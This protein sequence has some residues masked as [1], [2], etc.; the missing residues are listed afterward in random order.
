MRAPASTALVALE[1]SES[2]VGG[3]DHVVTPGR[4]RAGALEVV[5]IIVWNF[6]LG[7]DLL[8]SRVGSHTIYGSCASPARRAFTFNFN[9]NVIFAILSPADVTYLS[10]AQATS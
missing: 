10:A 1:G 4:F 3:A 7:S 5:V 8:R 6:V 9:F 2:R